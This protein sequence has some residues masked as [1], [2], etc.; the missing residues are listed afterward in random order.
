MSLAAS[1]TSLKKKRACSAAGNFF[2]RRAVAGQ[3]WL[4]RSGS[5]GGHVRIIRDKLG[6]GYV[7]HSSSLVLRML[8]GVDRSVGRCGG[9]RRGWAGKKPRIVFGIHETPPPDARARNALGTRFPPT[10]RPHTKYEIRPATITGSEEREGLFGFRDK[11]MFLPSS[12]AG[13]RNP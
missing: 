8:R 2:V 12:G 13:K 10:I 5:D 3:S 4:R 1:E 11:L 7:A 6:I 9:E